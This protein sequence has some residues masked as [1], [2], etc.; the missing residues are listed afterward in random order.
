MDPVTAGLVIAG[1]NL[2]GGVL[3]KLF[4]LGGG[5]GK[6]P[7]MPAAPL[8]GSGFQAPIPAPTPTPAPTPLPGAQQQPP[9][10]AI[11]EAALQRGL[12]KY[13]KGGLRFTPDEIEELNYIT[14]GGWGR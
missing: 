9:A 6:A 7:K 8:A 10:G 12:E 5:G 11:P 2:L 3:G 14:E 13:I 1:G 4:G